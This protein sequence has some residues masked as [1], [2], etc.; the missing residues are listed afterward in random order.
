MF[1]NPRRGRQ[2]RNFTTNV[3]KNLD[4]KSSSEQIFSE[5]DVG[6]TWASFYLKNLKFTCLE[7]FLSLL[8][9]KCKDHYCQ[10]AYFFFLVLSEV[11]K[12]RTNLSGIRCSSPICPLPGTKPGRRRVRKQKGRNLQSGEH[13]YRSLSL[14]LKRRT[15][16]S[17]PVK[18]NFN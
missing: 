2:A 17:L 9:L 15:G 11:P 7:I 16:I 1:E 18:G 14:D 5:I 8:R 6:C 10:C 12:V 3:P 13:Y 4:L